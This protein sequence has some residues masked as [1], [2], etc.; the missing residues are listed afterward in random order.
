METRC[1]L[2]F[3]LF[4]PT[5]QI[6]KD[7]IGLLCLRLNFRTLFLA[8]SWISLEDNWF[9]PYRSIKNI[10]YSLKLRYFCF[11]KIVNK[12]VPKHIQCW[13]DKKS[14]KCQPE[15]MREP[16]E[17]LYLDIQSNESF[18][19]SMSRLKKLI[20]NNRARNSWRFQIN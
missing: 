1:K 3:T 6:S 12:N 11:A 5:R 14:L 17:M 2:F 10:R 20:L 7:F 8:L 18:V 19:E 9:L 13:W 15:E 16:L 4:G